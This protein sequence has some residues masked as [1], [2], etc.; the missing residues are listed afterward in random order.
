[1]I[2]I[3]IDNTEGKVVIRKRVVRQLT[4]SDLKARREK[5]NKVKYI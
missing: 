2:E 3:K 5:W 4:L 1:L